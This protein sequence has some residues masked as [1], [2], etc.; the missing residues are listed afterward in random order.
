MSKPLG[1]DAVKRTLRRWQHNVLTQYECVKE[2]LAAI[3][4]TNIA[5]AMALIPPDLKAA[6]RQ[7]ID[8]RPR[9]EAEWNELKLICVDIFVPLR[10]FT[11]EEWSELRNPRPPTPEER[12]KM[13]AETELFRKYFA[14]TG[15][16]LA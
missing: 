1:L 3:N 4:D 11:R 7:V 15:E 5:E 9:T 14:S 8:Q 13:E 10:P 6:I 2:L 16:G 12:A